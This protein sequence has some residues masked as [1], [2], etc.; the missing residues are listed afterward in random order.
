MKRQRYDIFIS[1][2]R[3]GGA[4]YA[5][6]LQL[7]LEKRGY[8]V[9]LDYDELVDN[10]F[11]PQIEAA[12]RNST[13]YILLLSKGSMARCA[14]E[15]D[16]VRREIELAVAEHKHLIPVN[17]DGTFDGIPADVPDSIRQAIEAIQYSEISFGQALNATVDLM[18]RNR[19]R[20]YVR[21]RRVW[22][23]AAA[24]LLLIAGVAAAW[25]LKSVAD[26]EHL[27]ESITFGGNPVG[28]AENVTEEQLRAADEIFR[29]LRLIEGGSFM[30]GAQPGADG[31]YHENV[32]PEFETPAFK[33]D[34]APFYMGQ[35]EITVG[36]WN[37]I[38]G[39]N[40]PGPSDVPVTEVTYEQ[41]RQFAEALSDLTVKPFRLPTESEWEYAARGG[42]AAENKMYAGSDE[43]GEVAW[44][45]VNSVG[46][47]HSCSQGSLPPSCTADDLFNM[48]GNVSEW[49]DTEFA[50]YDDTF[51]YPRQ[52][53]M[54]VRG[55]NFNSETYEITV[56]HRE[57][58]SPHTSIPTLGFRIAMTK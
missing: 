8:R 2:R 12:I 1:Y 6:T 38:M 4:Q 9:F 51:E 23:Y 41:A 52:G 20:P 47:V 27:K 18:V 17:P 45:S 25:H 44:Y 54:T 14:N 5:R 22:P 7:M 30:Q 32:E 49:C 53:A 58:A 43:P 39:D 48:S 16:W 50:P 26:L 11:S 37:A 31:A 46:K 13:V 3:D 19:I 36:Q 33:A 21:R 57:P 56:T 10:R 24:V 34:V 15:G 28:W 35:F 40:R 55:G 29:S 42:A